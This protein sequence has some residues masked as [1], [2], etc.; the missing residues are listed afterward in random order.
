MTDRQ[1]RIRVHIDNK[2]YSVVGG[3]FQEMLAVVKQISGRR[4]VSELKVWQ[5]PGK[6]DEIQHQLSI[7]GF[8]LEGGEPLADAPKGNNPA[9]MPSGNDRIRVVVGPYRL[10]VVGGAFREMLDFVKTLPDR[11]FDGDN[12][13]WEINGDVGV[14]KG[15]VEAA[16]YQLEGAENIQITSPGAMEAPDFMPSSP[17]PPS[18]F[19]EPDFMKADF[20]DEGLMP[21]EPPDWWDEDEMPPPMMP[22]D[23]NDDYEPPAFFE[24]PNPFEPAPAME[25]PS[26][27]SSPPPPASSATGDRIRIRLGDTNLVVTGGAF[28]EMLAAIKNIPGRRFNGDEKIWEFPDDITFDSVSQSLNAAG[29]SVFPG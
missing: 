4:F 8:E 19:E 25:T 23:F 12:K 2:A 14:I 24:E 29:F 28:K 15:M 22:E 9:P 20:G 13:V 21:M 7:S 11:R 6:P 16:G 10:A 18:A 26:A 1:D 3:G 5:L 17:P 27:P